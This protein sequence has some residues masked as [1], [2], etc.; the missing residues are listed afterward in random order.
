[1]RQREAEQE[2][3]TIDLVRGL[4]SAGLH[5]AEG[6]HS[7][8]TWS[9]DG[10]SLA[11]FQSEHVGQ[12]FSASELHYISNISGI[13]EHHRLAYRKRLE[14]EGASALSNQRLKIG[15]NG[16]LMFDVVFPNA[17]NPRNDPSMN[18]NVQV[19]HSFDQ[20][21]WPSR[22]RQKETVTQMFAWNAEDESTVHGVPFG[23]AFPSLPG[24]N[25]AF[26]A[27]TSDDQYILSF[28]DRQYLG[29]E[30][31]ED[32]ADIYLTDVKKG[33]TR[34]VRKGQLVEDSRLIVMSPVGD[35]LAYYKEGDW[36]VYNIESETHRNVTAGLGQA[37]SETAGHGDGG[38]RRP[39]GVPG[40]S[41]DEKHIFIY[42]KFDIWLVDVDG[43]H[44]RRLTNGRETGIVHRISNEN[45]VRL[46]PGVVVTGQA[47]SRSEDLILTLF[48]ARR[49]SS[50]YA[51]LNAQ[52]AM[53]T[54]VL[55]NARI[56]QIQRAGDSNSFTFVRERFDIPPQIVLKDARSGRE[57]V[58]AN[59]NEQHVNY[60]WGHSEV[61]EYRTDD[62]NQLQAAIF[63][64]SG[65]VRGKKYPMITSIY[66]KQSDDVHAYRAPVMD[67]EY[68]S[69]PSFTAAGYI[70]L[71]PDIAH[72]RNAPGVSALRSVTAAVEKAIELGDVDKDR[73]GLIGFSFG[74]YET[75]Y[76]VTQTNLFAAAVAGAPVTD[77]ITYSL[78]VGGTQ[79]IPHSWRFEKQQFRIDGPYYD[80]IEEFVENSPIYQ[81][82]NIETPLL[83]WVGENDTQIES[84]QGIHLYNALRRMG[85]KHVLLMY[86][87]EGHFLGKEENQQD[88][89]NRVTAWF[90]HYLKGAEPE[91]WIVGN[92]RAQIP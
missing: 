26:S 47:I 23:H 62:G 7:T 63:Y 43:S 28:D 22:S 56:S 33:T 69:V 60:S 55:E 86:P 61:I 8:L 18:S 68:L 76:I 57:T 64:P 6:I 73:I 12:P 44:S 65:Y 77:L 52:G 10:N 41:D 81:A 83:T 78:T 25:H 89:Y 82:K 92:P 3:G 34:L 58:L 39:F 42:D 91:E 71:L 67:A 48:D 59:S 15:R 19:W 5:Q 75:A 1:V 29:R 80:R 21:I 32:R 36:W 35:Q 31:T 74:G 20:S 66:E 11:F 27:L 90:D 14:F 54:L 9:S 85:K 2:I 79:R 4:A 45:S 30:S 88:L 46:G 17:E 16:A 38:T 40:W 53:S 13:P 70:V 72:K 51:I 37:V 24:G 50:G 87:G 84:R 49:K